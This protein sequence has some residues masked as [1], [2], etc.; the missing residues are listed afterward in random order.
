[1]STEHDSVGIQTRSEDDLADGYVNDN[2]VFRE[3]CE[4]VGQITETGLIFAAFILIPSFFLSR[5]VRSVVTFR[6]STDTGHLL[7]LQIRF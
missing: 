5:F 3:S 2:R 4:H 6:V 7:K 1:M